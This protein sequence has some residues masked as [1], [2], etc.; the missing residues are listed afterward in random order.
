MLILIPKKDLQSDGSGIVKGKVTDS[1]TGEG[2]VSATAIVVGT[3]LGSVADIKGNY[4][5]ANIPTGKHKIRI[6]YV[7]YFPK[8]TEVIVKPNETVELNFKLIADLIEG[9]EI[10]VTAQAMGQ[11]EAINQQIASNTIKNIVSEDRIQALP[12]FNAAEAI[13]RLPGVSTQRSSGE[14]NKIVIRGLSPKHNLVAINNITLTS[15]GGG[16]TGT[17]IGGTVN[18]NVTGNPYG[19]Y[20]KSVDLTMITPNM[21][22]S[23]EVT[24]AL[25]PDMDGDAIGG[26]VNMKLKEAP[27]GFHSDLL[28]QSGYTKYNDR[29]NNYKAVGSVSDRFFDDALGVFLLGNIEQIDRSADKFNAQYYLQ[30]EATEGQQYAPIFLSTMALNRHFETRSRYG[31]NLILDYKI[32]GGKLV[33]MNFY[34]RLGSDYTDYATVRDARNNRVDYG[35]QKGNK[36]VDILSNALQG[37]NDFGF[38]SL[39]YS[40]A[41]NYSRNLDPDILNFNFRQEGAFI[42][43]PDANDPPEFAVANTKLDTSKT[44]L[45]FAGTNRN[46]YKEVSQNFAANFKIPFNFPDGG[47]SGYLK[48]GGK[49]NYTDR[50]NDQNYNGAQIFYGADR[51]MI[52]ALLASLPYLRADPVNQQRIFLGSFSNP[53]QSIWSN[54]LGN[55]YGNLMWAPSPDKLRP[56]LNV[57]DTMTNDQGK[58]RWASGPYEL[59]L[60]DFNYTEKFSAAYAMTEINFGPDI[61]F[62]GGVRYENSNREF[63]GYQMQQSSNRL[64]QPYTKKDTTGNNHYLLPMVHLRYKMTPGADIRYA[65]TQTL[66]R[67]DFNSMNP[68][69]YMTNASNYVQ[70]GNPGL[71]PAHAFNHDLIVSLYTNEIGL[72]TLGGFYKTIKD[73]VWQTTYYLQRTASEG[74]FTVNDFPGSQV[75]AQLDTWNNILTNSTVKGLEFDWQTRLWY[76]PSPFNGIVFN[77]NYTHI[78]S[79]TRYPRIALHFLPNPDNPRLP[80]K[81]NVDSSRI[82]RLQDQP[83]DIL[84]TSIGYDYGGFSGRISF[85]YQGGVLRGVGSRDEVDSETKEYLRF[86]LSLKQ[87]LPWYNLQ[88]YLNLNNLNQRSDQATQKTASAPTLQEFYG[89][90]A[91]LGIRYTF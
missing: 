84:N 40:I 90:T 55:K 69:Y 66:S 19:S 89:F 60:N 12:D 85:M 11:I 91:D 6:S 21:L 52:N 47:F 31:A 65:Y 58:K 9:N 14:G 16:A 27:G 57:L 71:R 35:I 43:K 30:G 49:Y 8:E 51:P 80:I 17:L 2:L 25:T 4:R 48:F 39:D 37:E 83:S 7:G 36:K 5:I 63:I 87:I 42:K 45:E 86:D 18:N 33:M 22:Q 82:G 75:G 32:P 34:S 61:M 81:V 15:T 76:L 46:D 78:W 38:I 23:I 44:W 88:I 73:F 67:P 1:Q 54:F 28:W 13:G 68:R 74:F 41:N 53:D 24:K 62:L 70:A 3:S 72:L 56:I 59:L 20:D 29:Y 64:T 77:V 50:K 26:S 79:E 10:V